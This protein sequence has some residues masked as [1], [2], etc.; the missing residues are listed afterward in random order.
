MHSL[1]I[2]NVTLVPASLWRG[3]EPGGGF[4]VPVVHF[5]SFKAVPLV[6]CMP[7][8]VSS[9]G[10]TDTQKNPHSARC[11]PSLEH[12]QIFVSATLV[13]IK[14]TR[15]CFW[16]CHFATFS[17]G[18]QCGMRIVCFAMWTLTL[19]AHRQGQPGGMHAVVHLHIPIHSR[20]NVLSHWSISCL[21]KF[22]IPFPAQTCNTGD[23]HW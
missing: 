17:R 16:V 13:F 10:P 1:L 18:T 23:Q 2:L 8:C 19:R 5:L 22:S 14:R 20:P 21:H 7:S 4:S 11:V 15:L 12:G 9:S 6:V 3:G